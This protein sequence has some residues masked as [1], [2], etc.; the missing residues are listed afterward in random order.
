M[1]F[2]NA[3][4]IDK[5]GTYEC[6]CVKGYDGTSVYKKSLKKSLFCYFSK[7]IVLIES[8][9]VATELKINPIGRWYWKIMDSVS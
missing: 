5:L 2:N 7:T 6:N 9:K 1:C 3:T 4:C 8:K